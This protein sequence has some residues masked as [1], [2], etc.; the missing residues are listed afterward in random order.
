M[1]ISSSDI[2]SWWDQH[3]G[4]VI[5]G[6]VG[7]R[8]PP[9][10]RPVTSL[11]RRA[12]LARRATDHVERTGTVS[13]E[14]GAAITAWGFNGATAAIDRIPTAD[15]EATMREALAL[16]DASRLAEAAGVVTRLPR[17]GVS[18]ASKLL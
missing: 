18:T 15:F 6:R 3:G 10:E 14:L 5:A 8:W 13:T 7:Y 17:I 12:E 2:D 11:R 9:A 1:R 16:A 4:D